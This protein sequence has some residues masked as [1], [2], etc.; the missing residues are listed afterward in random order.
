MTLGYKLFDPIKVATIN[1]I[2]ESLEL[3][4]DAVSSSYSLGSELLIL[5]SPMFSNNSKEIVHI[6]LIVSPKLV[7]Y[8]NL[9]SAHYPQ[10]SKHTNSR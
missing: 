10:Q 6:L 7:S 2:Q 5:E 1:S 3:S 4:L 9:L 8:C